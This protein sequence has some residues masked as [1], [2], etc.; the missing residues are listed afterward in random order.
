MKAKFHEQITP[1]ADQCGVCVCVRE[2]KDTF[3]E[4]RTYIVY[5]VTGYKLWEV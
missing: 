5:S 1:V 3:Y 4:R 2:I